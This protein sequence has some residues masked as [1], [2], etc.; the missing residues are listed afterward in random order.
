MVNVI[1]K[2]TAAIHPVAEI[3]GGGYWGQLLEI[4]AVITDGE[5]VEETEEKLRIA[6]VE[7]IDV[8]RERQKRE[9]EKMIL[10]PFA[11]A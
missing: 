2:L 11:I 10:R 7:Y 6:L 3:D 9:Q 8:L 4:P 5:S 1:P